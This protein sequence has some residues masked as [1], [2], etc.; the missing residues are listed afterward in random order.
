MFEIDTN[1]FNLY[2]V[3]HLIWRILDMFKS[4]GTA[5]IDLIEFSFEQKNE[6]NYFL[7]DLK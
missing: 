6:R 4:F 2:H 1:H 5:F 3:S 7:K